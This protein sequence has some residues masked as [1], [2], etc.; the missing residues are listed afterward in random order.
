MQSGDVIGLISLGLVIGIGAACDL[1]TK[2]IPVVLLVA[3]GCCVC[4]AAVFPN[5]L[6]MRERVFGMIPGVLFLAAGLLWHMIGTGDSILVLL[7][8]FALGLRGLSFFLLVSL[9]SL[10]P[11]A[12]LLVVIRKIGRKDTLPFY[13]FAAA[14]FAI[15]LLLGVVP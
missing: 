11:V 4:A 13:P 15:S 3:G 1:R 12:L 6:T 5:A 8:G 9:M 14:G 10:L 7:S 2:K